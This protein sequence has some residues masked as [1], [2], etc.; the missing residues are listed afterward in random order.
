MPIGLGSGL[1]VF[2]TTLAVSD[3]VAL[4]FAAGSILLSSCIEKILIA[5]K[6]LFLSSSARSLVSI[7]L[8][9]WVTYGEG[10]CGPQALDTFCYLYGVAPVFYCCIGYLRVR[11]ELLLRF[12]WSTAEFLRL[13]RK[14]WAANAQSYIVLVYLILEREHIAA[15]YPDEIVK[16]SVSYALAQLF[17]VALS[18]IAFSFQMKV[19]EDLENYNLNTHQKVT[20]NILI[21]WLVMLIA[22]IALSVVL[23]YMNAVYIGT[24]PS[25][26]LLV[27]V[28]GGYFALS[29]VSVIGLYIQ[30]S[31]IALIAL[32]VV[33]VLRT[34]L[35]RIGLL[36]SLQYETFLLLSGLLL[37][38]AAL[39]YERVIRATLAS[40]C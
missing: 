6:A 31:H 18:A 9:L 19:G 24:W 1:I 36:S 27:G 38:S 11:G 29:A 34:S 28:A 8:L 3:S 4:S 12:Y 37:F 15:H 35:D 23:S 5:R 17:F 16:Y 25:V 21:L 2:F 20:G 13:I 26:S 10:L 14:G 40:R 39:L 22:A 7:F 32:G 33:L 30:K